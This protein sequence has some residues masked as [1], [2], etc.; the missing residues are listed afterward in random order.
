MI[1][2]EE[3]AKIKVVDLKTLYNFVVDKLFIWVHLV[4]QMFNLHLVCYKTWRR[5]MRYRHNWGSGVVSVVGSMTLLGETSEL[6]FEP[7]IG[8]RSDGS[9]RL[10]LSEVAKKIC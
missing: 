4:P 7:A 9:S 8:G 1:S 3:I 5:K 10:V 6:C 2:D